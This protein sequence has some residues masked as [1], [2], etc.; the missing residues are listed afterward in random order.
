M[1]DITMLEDGEQIVITNAFV[2]LPNV[3]LGFDG[4]PLEI[5]CTV[6]DDGLTRKFELLVKCETEIALNDKP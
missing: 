1:N 6:S 2:Q 3:T 5:K 4:S